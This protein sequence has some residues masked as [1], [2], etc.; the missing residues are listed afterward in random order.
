M[1]DSESTSLIPILIALVVFFMFAVIVGSSQ[2]ER[3]LK[4]LLNWIKSNNL[5]LVRKQAVRLPSSL[6]EGDSDY[7]P[8]LPRPMGYEV[9]VK[10]EDGKE[11]RALVTI[12]NNP[13]A[14]APANVDWEGEN[15]A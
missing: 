9:V 2:Q 4:Q 1:D 3:A 7:A 15:D 8:W 14:V 10:G 11:R 5:T 12:D 13:K 6:D